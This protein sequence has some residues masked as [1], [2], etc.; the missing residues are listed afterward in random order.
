M[1]TAAGDADETATAARRAAIRA[2]RIGRPVAEDV[3]VRRT[4]PASG[5]PLGEYLQG[6]PEGGIECTWCGQQVA[7]ADADWKDCAVVRRSPASAAGP[8]RSGRFLLAEYFCAN[9]ATLLDTEVTAADDPPL[10]DR[11]VEW[12]AAGRSAR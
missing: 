8:G 7:P 6:S 3:A 12:P 2:D 1:V 11:I 9:C 10:Y 5:Q 4:V